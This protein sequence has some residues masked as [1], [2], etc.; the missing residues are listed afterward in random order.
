MFSRLWAEDQCLWGTSTSL[1]IVVYAVSLASAEYSFHEY[2][3]SC[4]YFKECDQLSDF[5]GGFVMSEIM[6]M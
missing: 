4:G 3:C 5:L 6:C 2:A 1:I